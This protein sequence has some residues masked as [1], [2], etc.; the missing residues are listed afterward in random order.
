MLLRF[1][2]IA[3][4]LRLLVAEMAPI[5]AVSSA[6]LTARTVAYVIG[7]ALGSIGIT[8]WPILVT[9]VSI[10]GIFGGTTAE[11]DAYRAELERIRL[12]NEAAAFA[13]APAIAAWQIAYKTW[14]EARAAYDTSMP[15]CLQYG[16]IYVPAI[17]GSWGGTTRCS[18]S[19]TY[20]GCI[21]FPPPYSV[22]APVYPTIRYITY[23]GCTPPDC[24]ISRKV[25]VQ[26]IWASPSEFG[27][28][29]KGCFLIAYSF[30][31][32]EGVKIQYNPFKLSESFLKARA[33]SSDLVAGNRFTELDTTN[34][35]DFE[36]SKGWDLGY[37]A[38]EDT[39]PECRGWRPGWTMKVK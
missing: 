33:K 12:A 19:Y 18:D 34:W 10:A 24:P 21:K 25:W 38:A 22:P 2:K 1:A 28:Q 8:L 27:S 39:D 37:W 6:M 29:S 35:K 17:C 32:V 31:K 3:G 26:V 30:D 20:N 36:S 11:C 7:F 16:S 4:G 23:T 14:V 13:A 15:D 9:L 5:V